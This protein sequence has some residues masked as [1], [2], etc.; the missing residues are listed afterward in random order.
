M[1]I[2]VANGKYM[3]HVKEVIGFDGSGEL[4]FILML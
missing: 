2:I 3:V 1:D 4:S